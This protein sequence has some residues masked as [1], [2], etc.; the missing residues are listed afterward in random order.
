MGI[1][2]V[3]LA[4]FCANYFEVMREAARGD[5]GA[6]GIGEWKVSGSFDFGL[7]PAL[8]MTGFRVGRD[9][10]AIGLFGVGV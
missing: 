5:K 2:R 10:W 3:V 9:R 6:E 4:G 1:D 8:R 7:R